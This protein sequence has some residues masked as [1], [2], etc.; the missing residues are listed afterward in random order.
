MELPIN[1]YDESDSSEIN[2]PDTVANTDRILR[3]DD[4]S[5]MPNIS[6][7]FQTKESFL[8]NEDILDIQ[9]GLYKLYELLNTQ[10]ELPD[11]LIFPETSSRPLVYAVDPIIEEVYSKRGLTKPRTVYVKTPDSMYPQVL[12]QIQVLGEDLIEVEGIYYPASFKSYYEDHGFPARD[13]DPRE[14]ED[15]IANE[16]NILAKRMQEIKSLGASNVLVIDDYATEEQNTIKFIQAELGSIPTHF[17]AFKSSIRL[18]AVPENLTAG[19]HEEEVTPGFRFK[20]NRFD[21]KRKA[22]GVEK[23]QGE[24]YASKVTNAHPQLKRWLRSRM[25]EIG[26]EV[27]GRIKDPQ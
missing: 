16:K 10:E 22:I 17:F 19:V 25:R 23:I 27:R 13:V 5:A 2:Q 14:I 1:S 12:Q 9:T 26:N 6:F 4:G 24:T 3:R 7:A 21:F 11:T 18:E 8:R 15:I 20:D